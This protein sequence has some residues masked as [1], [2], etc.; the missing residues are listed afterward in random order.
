LPPARIA[1]LDL[2]LQQSVIDQRPSA[3]FWLR[4]SRVIS[5]RLSAEF[6]FEYAV[7]GVQLSGAALAGIE[8][9]RATFTPAWNALTPLCVKSAIL[10]LVR[11]QP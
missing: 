4:L 8:A 11:P 2:V 5:P 9:S 7:G 6:T 3:Q 1:P 10:P